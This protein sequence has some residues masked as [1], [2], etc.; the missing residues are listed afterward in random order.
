MGSITVYE[1][2]ADP[3]SSASIDIEA[4]YQ[5]EVTDND[6]LLQRGDAD[7]SQQLDLSGLPNSQSSTQSFSTFESYSGQVDGAP[8]TFILIQFSNPRYII[9]TSG[10]VEPG[11]TISGSSFQSPVAPN[12][13]YDRLPSFVCFTAGSNILTPSGPRRVETLVPGDDVA[14]GEGVAKPLRW[15]GRRRLSKRELERN[16]RFCPVR[17]RANSFAPGCPS[18]DLLVS[19]QH[20]IAVSSAMMELYHCNPIMLAPAKGL[21]D[22]DAIDQMPP[23]QNIEYIHLLFDKHELVNVEGV[24]SESF[25]P[26][27]TTTEAM[28][29]ATRQE[30]F[31]LFPH[32]R[33]D[34]TGYGQTA[35]PVLK[36]YEVRLMQNAPT[37]PA[38][39]ERCNASGA[40]HAA[41]LSLSSA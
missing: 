6:G 12:V 18:C 35:L 25:Y 14:T 23:K 29:D 5:A 26:G 32:L 33:P 7:G 40:I 21:I 30:L 31:A 24:W 10:T 39:A 19:P 22:G 17:I 2:N 16:P 15:I 13:G 41:P 34:A 27:P 3:F 9:V 37:V 20:R 28:A 36:P 1:I 8:V 38:N 11:D 4:A